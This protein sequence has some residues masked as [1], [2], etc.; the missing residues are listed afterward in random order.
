MMVVFF[1]HS[2]TTYDTPIEVRCLRI[3]RQKYPNCKIVNPKYVQVPGP[4]DTPEDFANMMEKYILPIVRSCDVLVYYK[5]D[6]YSPGVDMEIA[7]A[8]G[9]GIPVYRLEV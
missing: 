6:S 5:D 2:L 9:L 1:S 3:V 7:E 8:S 4:L